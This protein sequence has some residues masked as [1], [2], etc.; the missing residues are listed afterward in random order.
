ML[1]LTTVFA[2]LLISIIHINN[3]QI[4]DLQQPDNSGPSYL[5]SEK[6]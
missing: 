5:D 2:G 1:C 3:W 6:S 4:D